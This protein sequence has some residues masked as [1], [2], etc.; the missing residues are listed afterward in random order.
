MILEI[1]CEEDLQHRRRYRRQHVTENN[2]NKVCLMRSPVRY[3]F[4]LSIYFIP[5]EF[6]MF[7][8]QNQN[9]HFCELFIS[10]SQLL[11]DA[12]AFALC[13]QVAARKKNKNYNVR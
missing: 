13:R 10:L 12:A 9:L 5:R 8:T 6:V 4:A 1:F 11:R 2:N 3:V 7:R